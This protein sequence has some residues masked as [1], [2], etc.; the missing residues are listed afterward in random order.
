MVLLCCITLFTTCTY[1]K[2]DSQE[3]PSGCYPD[4]IANIFV[5]KCA[6][7]GCHTTQSK[8]QAGGFDL[9]SW[10]HLFEGGANGSSVIPY[11][12]D[13]SFL[14]YFINTYPDLNI[15]ILQ[16]T[17]PVN[18]T[19]LSHDEVV[20][21]RDWIRNGAPDCN[22]NI[23][24]SGDPN[25][26]KFY[27]CHRLTDLVTVFDS[28]SLLPM[29]IISVGDNPTLVEG[30]HDVR[31]SPD[32]NYWYV[33][34]YA[35]QVVQKFRTSDDSYVG[36]VNIG[37]GLWNA[38]A[39]TSD[40]RYG[41]VVN[42]TAGGN[43]A[44]IDLQSMTLMP[45]QPFT[46]LNSPHGVA[47]SSDSKTLYVTAQTG[48]YIYKFD[49]TDPLNPNQDIIT[50][51]NGPQVFI[52]K[53]DPHQIVISPDGT[54]YYITCQASDE[55]R[56]MSVA[57][58]TLIAVIHTGN[59]PQELKFS[60]TQPYLFVTCMNDS[61]TFPGSYGSVSVIN[62]QTNQFVKAIFSGWQPHGLDV[63]D[64]NGKVYV[65]NRNISP[66][67]PAPHHGTGSNRNGY[68]TAIDM[69]TLDL[70]PDYQVEVLADPYEVGVRK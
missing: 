25:R 29:R 63:D 53:L 46:G 39:I 34:F 69:N 55:V 12:P 66:N 4:N 64:A 19:P 67:G 10:N 2:E 31:V 51:E 14:M 61:T 22:G 68:V 8:D 37:F 48:N 42:W 33:N 43:V 36:E 13:Q 15:P 38:M 41:F 50:L 24:F 58:D 45:V 47:I 26:K 20:M 17:M 16:P 30:A 49:I 52:S 23:K 57:T 62:Y 54:K 70:V 28:H 40:S 21:V 18:E 56:V 6:V 27:V 59:V 7:P 11:S 65:A 9:S 32:G 44:F 35:G 60:L 3:L 1:D 5:R